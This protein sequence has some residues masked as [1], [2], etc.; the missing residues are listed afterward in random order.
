MP[1]TISGSFHLF[2]LIE[3][4]YKHLS[5]MFYHIQDTLSRIN[6]ENIPFQGTLF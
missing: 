2:Y 6:P 4:S 1:G 3:L 5:L